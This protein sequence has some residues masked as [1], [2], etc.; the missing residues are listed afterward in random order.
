MPKELPPVE[1]LRKLLRY[2]PETGKLFWRQRSQDMFCRNQDFVRW[3]NRYSETEAM[4]AAH[5]NGYK[6]GTLLKYKNIRAHRAAWA[7]YYGK[8]PT[9]EIDHIDGDKQNNKICNLR[10]VT[11]SINRKNSKKRTDNKSGYTGVLYVPCKKKYMARIQ[12]D[13]KIKCKL[14][15]CKHEANKWRLEQYGS[16]GF[17]ERHG[18]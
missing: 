10:D 14:F 1:L 11:V 6:F 12:S 4:A 3:N 15:D 8:W 18:T 5:S 13:N 17:T 16:L 9:G 7:I 2:E